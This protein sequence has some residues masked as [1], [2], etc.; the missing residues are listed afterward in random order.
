M[1]GA[2]KKN[3]I[4]LTKFAGGGSPFHAKVNKKK[5]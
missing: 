3:E 2:N 1:V 5:I 4:P